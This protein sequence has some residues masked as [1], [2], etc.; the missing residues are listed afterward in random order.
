MARQQ[1]RA[2]RGAVGGRGAGGGGRAAGGGRGGCAGRGAAGGGAIGAAAA[3]RGEGQGGGGGG[4]GASAG[5]AAGAAAAG[6]AAAGAG[7]A[8]AAAG[9]GGGGGGGAA[10]RRAGGGAPEAGRREQAAGTAGQGDGRDRE[11][12]RRGGRGGA[13]RAPGG[14][15]A[16]CRVRGASARRAGG[17]PVA[18]AGQLGDEHG[19]RTQGF[20][21]ESRAAVRRRADGQRV[22]W[23]AGGHVQGAAAAGQDQGCARDADPA[24]LHLMLRAA[25]GRRRAK[26]QLDGLMAAGPHRRDAGL[27]REAPVQGLQ[28]GRLRPLVGR[29]GAGAG[30]AVHAGARGAAPQFELNGTN[31]DTLYF[32]TCWLHPRD[33]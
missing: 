20:A 24:T 33:M 1:R 26:R 28:G 31:S 11:A 12:A 8:G 6:S 7:T 16:G 18:R 30:A 10:A 27:D 29:V 19:A 25:D 22:L 13:A 21:A 32:M 15:T 23:R 14:R 5:A 9:A 17:A 4:A 2:A 3:A